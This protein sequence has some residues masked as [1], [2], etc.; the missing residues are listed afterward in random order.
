MSVLISFF[1]LGRRGS[2]SVV[3]HFALP[4]FSPIFLFLTSD[5]LT[6]LQQTVVPLSQCNSQ[7]ISI[8]GEITD[9][10]PGVYVLVFDNTF[11]RLVLLPY[12]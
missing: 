7:Q 6:S 1:D 8:K 11:S 4:R 5:M 10:S 2:S 9:V 12:I 3:F